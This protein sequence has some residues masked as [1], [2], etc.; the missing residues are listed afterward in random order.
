MATYDLTRL[1]NIINLFKYDSPKDINVTIT[2][3]VST[4]DGIIQCAA[5]RLLGL[6]Q[7]DAKYLIRDI[8][9]ST[10]FIEK[11]ISNNYYLL[12]FIYN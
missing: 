2:V 11:I 10:S 8:I 3:R 1:I 12:L 5:E 7:A 4:E 9:M 6:S